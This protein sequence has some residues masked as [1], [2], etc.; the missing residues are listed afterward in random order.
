MN[1]KFKK[2]VDRE[3]S[4]LY[5]LCKADD[6]ASRCTTTQTNK[7]MNT[8]MKCDKNACTAVLDDLKH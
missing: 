6:G 1:T 3:R 4:T 5:E 7:R 2:R 8:Y